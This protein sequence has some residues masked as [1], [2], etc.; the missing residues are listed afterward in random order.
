MKKAVIINSTSTYN[1]LGCYLTMNGL[2]RL[3]H[4]C[5]INVIFE[6]EVNNYDFC[7]VKKLLDENKSCFLIINGEGTIHDDQPYATA[8][9]RFAEHYEKRTLILNSQLKNM[10]SVYIEIMKRFKLVQLRTRADF[11]Y[12]LEAGLKNI[13]YCPDML[14]NS[15]LEPRNFSKSNKPSVVF[16]DSHDQEQSKTLFEM[17]SATPNEVRKWCNIHYLYT[18]EKKS[19]VKSIILYLLAKLAPRLFG[20][21]HLNHISRS[22]ISSTLDTLYEATIIVTA[23]YHTACIGI[24][25]GKKIFYGSSNTTKVRDIC[26]DF[27]VGAPLSEINSNT[28]TSPEKAQVPTQFKNISQHFIQLVVTVNDCTEESTSKNS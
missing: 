3:L 25:A 9:L 4:N 2:R 21:R 11:D 12:A 5:S 10:S 24:L 15:G 16:T 18:G 22:S 23:R 1:H 19:S 13:A 20:Y 28:L 27:N 17:Y 6:L 14:F 26:D 7:T 8:L